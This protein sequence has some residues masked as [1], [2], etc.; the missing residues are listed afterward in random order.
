MAMIKTS[1]IAISDIPPLLDGNIHSVHQAVIPFSQV[2][3][4][5]RVIYPDADNKDRLSCLAAAFI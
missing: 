3:F 2:W 4:Q 5:R 1:T